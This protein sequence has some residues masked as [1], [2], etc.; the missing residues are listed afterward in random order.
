[1]IPYVVV[2]AAI[3]YLAVLE[4]MIYSVRPATTPLLSVAIIAQHLM[5][6]HRSQ[7]TAV[8]LIMQTIQSMAALALIPCVSKARLITKSYSFMA[9]LPVLNSLS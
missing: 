1:M 5:L 8:W 9:I 6:A 3:P 7:S 2:T 4:R